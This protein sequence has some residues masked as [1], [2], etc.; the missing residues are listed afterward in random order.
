[1]FITNP[2]FQREFSASSRSVKTNFLIWAYLL[3]LALVILVLWPAGGIH[4]VASSSSKQI[5]AL[6]F[7]I[8][9]TLILLMVPAF[10]ATAISWEKENN[11]Y[12]SLFITMLKPYEMFSTLQPV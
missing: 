2:I 5:F 11:T 4:S 6:F 1:M 10:S 12:D 9:L 8:N 3:L 7:S